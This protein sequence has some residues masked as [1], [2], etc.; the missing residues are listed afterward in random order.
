MNIKCVIECAGLTEEQR[1][2]LQ[3]EFILCEELRNPPQ[4]VQ[5]KLQRLANDAAYRFIA[6]LDAP[7]Y[8]EPY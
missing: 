1:L 5:E 7:S 6:G 4:E 8:K 2:L 3:E